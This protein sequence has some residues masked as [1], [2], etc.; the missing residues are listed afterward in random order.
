MLV[1]YATSLQAA[2]RIELSTEPQVVRSLKE[3]EVKAIH[4]LLCSIQS[5]R[6]LN[7]LPDVSAVQK[8]VYIGRTRENRHIN[9]PFSDEP[10]L[11]LIFPNNGHGSSIS[12]DGLLKSVII[13]AF[14]RAYRDYDVPQ[15]R[16][17]VER[18]LPPV[19]RQKDNTPMKGLKMHH[20]IRA[21]LNEDWDSTDTVPWAEPAA[22]ARQQIHQLAWENMQKI[23]TTSKDPGVA[24][25]EDMILVVL[26]PNVAHTVTT[27]YID[28]NRRGDFLLANNEA[29][30]FYD[31]DLNPEYLGDAKSVYSGEHDLTRQ[32]VS[33]ATGSGTTTFSVKDFFKVTN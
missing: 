27:E 21:Y 22:S 12:A 6:Q 8:A 19:Y 17:G 16:G 1:F 33:G 2:Q 28:H 30:S 13:P 15:V 9:E 24:Q 18:A 5:R 23:V 20:E 14:S 4:N 7:T 25:L 29:L 3:R 11:Y 26:I 31:H 10:C 32:K